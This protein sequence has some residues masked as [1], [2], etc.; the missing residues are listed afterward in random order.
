MTAAIVLLILI[1][2]IAIGLIFHRWLYSGPGMDKA[3]SVSPSF[4]VGLWPVGVAFLVFILL[5]D[6]V[7]ASITRR[8]TRRKNRQ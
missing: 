1:L 2:Y 7:G 4:T 3:D 5:T 6:V 8:I